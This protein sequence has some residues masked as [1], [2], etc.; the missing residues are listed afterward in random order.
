MARYNMLGRALLGLVVTAALTGG[1]ALAQEAAE[2]TP[3]EDD[4]QALPP[5]E[6]TADGE[7]LL[8]DEQAVQEEQAPDETYRSSTDPHEDPDKRY[9][10]AG[11]VWRYVRLPS[12]T[13]EWFLDAAPAAGTAGSFLGE[14]GY[15]HDGFQVTAEIGW[16]NFDFK[17]PFQV[18]GDPVEDTEWLDAKLNMLMATATLTWST[19]FTEWLALEYGIEGGLAAVMGT[20]RRTE[21]VKE[22]GKWRACRGWAGQPGV[23]ETSPEA[24]IYCDHPTGNEQVTNGADEDGAHYNVPATKGLVNGGVPRAVPVLGPRL[25]LRFKPIHQLVLRVDVPLPVLPYGFVGGVAAHYG[26]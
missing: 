15:R 20:V 2:P 4:T 7:P 14:F 5:A 16:M 17:G 8:G 13:L 26:F 24:Q 21:A 19:S 9:F 6:A 18:S 23:N 3:D 10:F 22:N 25:S 12:W 1:K 11:A